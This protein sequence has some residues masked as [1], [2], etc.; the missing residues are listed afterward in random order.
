[1]D[2]VL[3]SKEVPGIRRH[4]GLFLRRPVWVRHDEHLHVDFQVTAP[5]KAKP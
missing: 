2:L 4:A 3:A 5:A 1:V